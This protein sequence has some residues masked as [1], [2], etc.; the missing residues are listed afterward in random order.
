[1][2]DGPHPQILARRAREIVAAVALAVSD[3]PETA[4]FKLDRA[5]IITLPD[6]A[7]SSLRSLRQRLDPQ[8]R[9]DLLN[10]Y[11]H[12]TYA[13]NLTCNHCYADAGPGRSAMMAVDDVEH[14][15]E[16]VRAAGFRKVVITGGE[17]L[18]HFQ[19]DA[20]LD[21]L[22]ALRKTSK[23]LEIV[24]RTNL[25]GFAPVVGSGG[26]E[27]DAQSRLALIERLT[28]STD[29][30]IVSVDGDEASHDARRGAGTYAQTV[31]NLRDLAGFQNHTGQS[32]TT[33][34]ITAVLTPVQMQGRE[35]AA[36]RGLARELNIPIRFKSVLP[37]G[38]G[39]GLALAPAFYRSL[40]D[41]V[42]ALSEGVPPSATC[43]L[44]MNLYIAPDGVCYPCYALMGTS[45]ILGNAFD[46]LATVLERNSVYRR[47]TV[48]S[49]QQCR[50]CDLRYLCGGFCRAWSYIPDPDGPPTECVALYAQARGQLLSALHTLGIDIAQ[51][52]AAGLPFPV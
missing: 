35:A 45:H 38:R 51:W 30:V 1:M 28:Y 29:R 23:P 49:N 13:C 14:L 42:E 41:D 11:L 18:L 43:G 12:V 50:Q 46:G 40:D 10:A 33:V 4:L 31:A 6:Q 21:G 34:M 7:L 48:D 25:A 22:A 24:L 27:L 16:A 36:V 26:C 20:L 8:S 52:Q 2:R 39:A 37:L 17:P 3:S 5:G 32:R 19:R 9:P 15:I 47:V 44:G